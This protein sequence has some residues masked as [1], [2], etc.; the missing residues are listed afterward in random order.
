[1][2]YDHI[3]Y[4]TILD[5]CEEEECRICGVRSNRLFFKLNIL[6]NLKLI[7]PPSQIVITSMLVCEQHYDGAKHN[8]KIAVELEKFHQ[9]REFYFIVCHY[10][11]IPCWPS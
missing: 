10:T 5:L 1:M 8:R 9:A 7:P 3:I 6:P 4:Q 2:D 11:S